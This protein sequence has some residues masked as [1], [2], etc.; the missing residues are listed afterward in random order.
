[1]LLKAI[2]QPL[3]TAIE[4]QLGNSQRVLGSLWQKLK[5]YVKAAGKCPNTCLQTVG[6]KHSCP[7]AI[8][9]NVAVSVQYICSQGS[10][11]L[12]IPPPPPPPMGEGNTSLC[13]FGRK[14][15]TKGR[16]KGEM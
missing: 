16:K 5:G 4:K 12:K 7:A 3:G 10:M 13:Q 9:Q 6:E 2:G 8:C 1:M 14:N 15:M 11:Y